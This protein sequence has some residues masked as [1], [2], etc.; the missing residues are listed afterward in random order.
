[1]LRAFLLLLDAMIRYSLARIT[2]LTFIEN[3]LTV[4]IQAPA[5]NSLS[6]RPKFSEVNPEVLNELTGRAFT[7]FGPTHC[8]V[9][10][11]L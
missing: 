4:L 1:M 5:A 9:E 8:D 2:S 6:V 7:H 10:S 3:E 11:L